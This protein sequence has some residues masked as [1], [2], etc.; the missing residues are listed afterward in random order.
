M[1]S[2]MHACGCKSDCTG[3]GDKQTGAIWRRYEVLDAAEEGQ[4]CRSGRGVQ[5]HEWLQ[6]VG[7]EGSNGTGGPRLAG[8]SRHSSSVPSQGAELNSPSSYASSVAASA[9]AAVTCA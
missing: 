3:L 2:N 7:F 9:S 4:P 5:L 6:A 8:R 1:R